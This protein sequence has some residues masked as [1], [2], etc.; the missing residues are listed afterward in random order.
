MYKVCSEFDSLKTYI[1][2][3]IQMTKTKLKYSRLATFD[4]SLPLTTV[5]S[6]ST[7]PYVQIPLGFSYIFKH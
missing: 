3:K 7:L 6:T 1:F 5:L 2:V 4:K